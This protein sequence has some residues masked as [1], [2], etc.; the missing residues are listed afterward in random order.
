MQKKL[1]YL[2]FFSFYSLTAVAQLT[3]KV[4]VIPLNTPANAPIYLVGNFNNWNPGDANMV[5]TKNPDGTRQITIQP[6]PGQLE[7]KFTRGNWATVE[8]D[9]QGG[10]LPNRVLQYTG[11]AQTVE[12]SI[13]T[14][15][16]LAGNNNDGSTAASNVLIL[17]ETFSM[18]QLDRTRRVWIYLPPDY[19]SSNKRY[20]VLYL[21][22]G[23]NVFD[24]K[25][26][27]SGEW[28]VDEALNALFENGDKGIIAVAID[29]GGGNR[30][31][32]YSPWI[33][34]TYGGGQGDEYA[35]F[36]VETLKPH[37]DATYRTRPEREYTGMMGSSMGG[38]IAM[39]A[40]IEYQEVFSKI[41]VFS[42]AFWF[43]PQC[44]AHVSG[45]GKE[46]DMKI[47]LLAGQLEGNGSVV[48]DVNAM[49][50][51]LR[52]AGFSENE[53]ITSIHSDGQHSEWFW[54]RE[55]PDAY[56]WLFADAISTSAGAPKW[57]TTIALSPNPA[58]ST[59][60]VQNHTG[61]RDISFRIFTADG[62]QLKGNAP[63]L[64]NQIE[65][66]DLPA[67]VYVVLFYKQNRIIESQKIVVK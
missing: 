10:Q 52:N 21:H 20:P 49:Y 29:N 43:A 12:L 17:S 60:W 33:N 39:Y 27:F 57:H 9:A 5:L 65:V 66:A 15:E 50:N 19:N 63:L 37:I 41:G 64:N 16:D 59:I 13:L 58:D 54:A 55:F 45:I 14:W 2:L 44:Y 56:Q 6:S 36:I 4:G 22:D 30:I 25:T 26:S 1:F 53:V 35:Q 24:A 38:L 11:Q 31:N 32:E 46:K 8:G 40:G 62:R 23:Q 61:D 3:I 28:K 51:T 34:P 18:P 42:P 48:A 47:Y 7:F 67:G